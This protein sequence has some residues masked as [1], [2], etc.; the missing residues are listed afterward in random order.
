VTVNAERELNL[1]RTFVELAD[2]LVTGFDMVEFL[3]MLTERCVDILG[4]GA[5]GLMLV[6]DRG[7]L[8]IMAASEERAHLLEL[9]QL[10]NNE[11]PCLDCCRSGQAVVIDDL[12][13]EAERWPTFAPEARAAGFRSVNA[14]PMRLRNTILGALNLFSGDARGLD[15]ADVRVAQALADVATIG[16]LHER[17]ATDAQSL[18]AQLHTALNSRVV[19]EQAKGLLAERLQID[20]DEA[21]R[22]LRGYARQAKRSLS[23]VAQDLLDGHLS[24][25]ALASLAAGVMGTRGGIAPGRAKLRR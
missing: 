18:V 21:F 24:S 22:L 11:G 16:I 15:D 2:T 10:Q 3:H 17:A 6:D 8:R 25:T 9:F 14:V 13:A 23:D 4:V 20:M 19:I 7:G 1:S 5:A 12:D